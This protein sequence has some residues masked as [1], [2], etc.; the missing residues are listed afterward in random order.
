M[1]HPNYGIWFGGAV[2]KG[3]LFCLEQKSHQHKGLCNMI[4]SLI[5]LEVACTYT[6]PSITRSMRLRNGVSSPTHDFMREG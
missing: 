4:T 6:T 1:V 3:A 2:R 5:G